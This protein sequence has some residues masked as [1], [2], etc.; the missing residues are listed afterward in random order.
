VASGVGPS[1][2]LKVAELQALTTA[3]S[4][5]NAAE[6]SRMPNINAPAIGPADGR[7]FRFLG[8]R[9]AALFL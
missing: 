6:S 4:S 2:L 1:G 5:A 7:S 3:P 8:T 9:S